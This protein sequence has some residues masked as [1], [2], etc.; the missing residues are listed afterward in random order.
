MKKMKKWLLSGLLAVLMLGSVL[1]VRAVG[2]HTGWS[3]FEGKK[4]SILSASTS[5]YDGV[6]NNTA[7][8]STIGKNDVYYTEGRHGVYQKDMWWQQVIDVLD[9]ELLVDNA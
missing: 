2:E 8:N 3:R 5:T 6:S 9:M 1:S 4:V 7:A